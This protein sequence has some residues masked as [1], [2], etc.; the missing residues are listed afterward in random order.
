MACFQKRIRT[1][2]MYLQ[3][4]NSA[5]S[6]HQHPIDISKANVSTDADAHAQTSKSN[7]KPEILN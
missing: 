7:P 2:D 6:L 5:E 3:V 1:N 4:K